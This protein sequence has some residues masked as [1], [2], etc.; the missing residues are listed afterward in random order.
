MK[1]IR[2]RIITRLISQWR[3]RINESPKTTVFFRRLR[4][5]I[6]VT[7]TVVLEAG[8][9]FHIR[10]YK[11]INIIHTSQSPAIV[12]IGILR[13]GII[14]IFLILQKLITTRFKKGCCHESNTCYQYMFSFHCFFF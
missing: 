14:I 1:I 12:V 8:C 10:H 6:R 7:R 9:S 4:L 13:T 11:L 5:R 2:Y 3:T